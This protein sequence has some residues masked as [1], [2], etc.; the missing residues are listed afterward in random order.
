MVVLYEYENGKITVNV[1]PDERKPVEEYLMKQGRF[2]HLTKAQIA[3]IQKETDKNFY[4]L[5][6]E[7]SIVGAKGR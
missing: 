7:K 6:G 5:T 4:Q 3:G 2:S 1:V